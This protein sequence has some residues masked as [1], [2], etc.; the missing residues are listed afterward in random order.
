MAVAEYRKVKC[1]NC[2]KEKIV[3]NSGRYP[4]N[5]IVISINEWIGNIGHS[6]YC[7][8]VCSG[9]CAI[10]LLNNLK[11]LPKREAIRYRI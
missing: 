2:E 8:D 6:R 3:K 5:W 9:K 1:D 4:P 11:K 10:D 7:K